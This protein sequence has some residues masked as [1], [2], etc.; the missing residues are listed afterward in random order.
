MVMVLI[1]SAVRRLAAIA[2]LLLMTP[3]IYA[4]AVCAGWSASAAERL[5]CCQRSG[6]ACATLSADDCC[7][8]G[9][10]RQNLEQVVAVPI[11]RS[12]AVSYFIPRTSP[13]PRSFV[14][15]PVSLTDRP[16]TYLLDS[17]FLI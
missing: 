8:E 7:A 6:D 16:D 9:E 11:T 5:A 15:D 13:R 12:N 3:V 1:P 4:G 10:Q 2:L 17:V 14:S